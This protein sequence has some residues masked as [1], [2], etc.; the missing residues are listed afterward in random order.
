MSISY[1]NSSFCDISFGLNTISKCAAKLFAFFLSLGAQVWSALL[2]RGVGCV[3]CF[4]LLVAFQ[5][6]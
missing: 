3:G 5:S 4:K 2:I 6:E 1:S